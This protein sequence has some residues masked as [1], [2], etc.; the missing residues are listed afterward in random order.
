[1]N[2]IAFP[3]AGVVESDR[4]A[5]RD[6]RREH[7]LDVDAPTPFDGLTVHFR[8]T[9]ATLMRERRVPARRR[10]RPARAR[11]QRR[12]LDRLYDVGDR[13]A[14]AARTIAERARR[15]AGTRRAAG[16]TGSQSRRRRPLDARG[17]LAVGPD[18]K[19]V[20]EPLPFAAFPVFVRVCGYGRTWD[21]QRTSRV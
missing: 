3:K 8:S 12:A 7:G 11:R 15:A 4:R 16:G 21:R 9:A 17:T 19:R 1:M 14:R 5:T 20:R 10:G 2:P 13:S 18:P 6:Y